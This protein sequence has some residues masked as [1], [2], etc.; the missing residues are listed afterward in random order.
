MK[1]GMSE[2]CFNKH[3]HGGAREGAGRP[4]LGH[5]AIG[6]RLSSKALAVL[7]R[8]A[9]DCGMSKSKVIETLLLAEE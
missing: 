3:T 6:L 9:D 2:Q 4:R 5:K 8:M 7:N 1:E